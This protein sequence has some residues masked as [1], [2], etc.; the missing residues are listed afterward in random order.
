MTAPH[1]PES[2]LGW[3]R[4]VCGAGIVSIRSMGPAATAMHVIGVRDSTG[5]IRNLVLRRY[6]DIERLRTDPWY[7]PSNEAAVLDLLD[8][9]DVLAP[10]LLAADVFGRLSDVPALLMTR[11]PGRPVERPWDMRA[12]LTGLAEALASIHEV[13]IPYGK[14]LPPYSTYFDPDRGDVRRPPAWSRQPAMWERVFEVIEDEQPLEAAGGFIHRDFHLG[15]TLWRDG[16][17]TGVCDW[18]TGCWGPFGIDLA[19]VRLNLAMDF[20]TG[21]SE[22]FA[23]AYRAVSGAD[24]R[25]P[26]WDLLDAADTVLSA[27][28]NAVLEEW[29]ALTLAEL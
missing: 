16:R 6:D 3:I 26:Y 1:P 29:V 9:T 18:T 17:L 25:H 19:H 22:P 15:Q 4:D 8:G 21:A 14:A 10:R 5:S 12:F 11:L 28:P 23:D 2:V 13:E 20:G 24:P 7:S 27:E